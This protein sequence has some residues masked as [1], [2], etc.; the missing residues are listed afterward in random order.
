MNIIGKYIPLITL[1]LG[2]LSS[3]YVTDLYWQGK[4]TAM[5]LALEQ[6]ESNHKQKI[7]EANLASKERDKKIA[8]LTVV[9]EELNNA[10]AKTIIKEVVKYVETNSNS[11]CE[12][13]DEWVRIADSSTPM[14]SAAI[15]TSAP[16]AEITSLPDL[17]DALAV[18]THNYMICQTAVTRYHLWQDWYLSTLNDE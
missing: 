10:K 4:F 16:D 12:L 11:D 3:W 1:A 15:S 17:G 18:M 13:D 5:E 14:S 7:I 9:K 2:L 6:A 8:E